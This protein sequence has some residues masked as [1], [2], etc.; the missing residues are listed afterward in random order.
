MVVSS[1]ARGYAQA[2]AG[3]LAVTPDA[4][5]LRLAE[6]QGGGLWTTTTLKLGFIGLF[7]L[8]H[9]LA[10]GTG[11]VLNGM[12][13]APKHVFLGALG[14]GVINMGYALAFL[15]TS[16]ADALM[17][18]SLHPLWAALFAR[19]VL[20]EQLPRRTMF[21][22]A[23]AVGAVLLI[24][25]P[26][27]AGGDENY[28][29]TAHGNL[30][31]VAT[32]VTLA[33]TIV[34]N[35]HAGLHRPPEAGLGMEAAAGLGSL[36][37]GLVVLPIACSVDASSVEPTNATLA[38]ATLANASA[39]QPQHACAAFEQLE[40]PFWPLVIADGAC[41]AICTVLSTVFAPRHL[42]SA[43]VGLVLLGEQVLSPIWVYAGVGEAPSRWTIAGGVLLLSTLALHEAAALRD[44]R[45][46]A[47]RC[48]APPA[49][50]GNDSSSTCDAGVEIVKG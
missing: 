22:L 42:F 26:Q 36:A 9:P 41:I 34:V 39:P 50:S 21:A 17:L 37:C 29:G 1:R 47:Q 12:R 5:L 8:F 4:V 49:A 45:S 19:I 27:L 7:C 11:A 2:V 31:A 46:E 30:I 6:R 3:T 35:R 48:E 40:P 25:V 44:E 18:I 43:E 10:E 13:A 32:G 16:V 24:F 33:F 28:G 15:T 14:Q 38:N 20:R 23:V